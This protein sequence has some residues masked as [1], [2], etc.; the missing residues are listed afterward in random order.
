MQ[1]PPPN[2]RRARRSLPP[3]AASES[4]PPKR[5]R[6]S[7]RRRFGVF[8]P[9]TTATIPGH[10][11]AR[12]LAPDRLRRPRRVRRRSAG[13]SCS[14]SARMPRS[15][16]SPTRSASTR[17]AT[18]RL[19]LWCALPYLPV[20]FHVAVVDPGVGT[21]RRPLAILTG[22]GDVLIGPDNGL[23]IA[24]GRAP[25]RRRRVARAPEPGLP[26]AGGHQHVPRPRHV[27]AG[28]GAPRAGRVVRVA[29]AGDRRPPLVA[30]PLPAARVGRRRDRDRGRVRGHVRQRE[31]V[32]DR[33]RRPR[34]AR[35]SRSGRTFAITVDGARTLDVRWART[36]GDLEAGD[37]LLYEDSYG[38]ACIGVNQ[39]SAVASLGLRDGNR[40]ELR[41]R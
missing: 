25:R 4:F 5:R 37:P 35:A 34:R 28:R 9:A 26:P 41:P 33:R 7:S 1:C 24:G 22:R 11:P 38:R 14:G 12:R 29:G 40:L 17:S 10:D 21:A 39:G 6:A 2:T 27:R 31:A 30:S 36:F 3:P 15:S 18:G 20:G 13:R 8:T 19:L 32:G 16:T 23:L